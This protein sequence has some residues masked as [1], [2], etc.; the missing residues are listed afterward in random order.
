MSFNDEKV[1]REFKK[2]CSDLKLDIKSPEKITEDDFAEIE[3]ID[4]K[5]L[6]IPGAEEKS[7]YEDVKGKVHKN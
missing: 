4:K 6:E 3:K 5:A 7:T 1:L 2:D